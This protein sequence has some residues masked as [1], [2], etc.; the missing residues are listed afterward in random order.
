[1]VSVAKGLFFLGLLAVS[2]VLPT[3]LQADFEAEEGRSRDV[4]R[5]RSV[6]TLATNMA[7][8]FAGV[9][10]EHVDLDVLCQA[11][12]PLADEQVKPLSYEGY[13]YYLRQY[14][15]RPDICLQVEKIPA[16]R[17]PVERH[18]PSGGWK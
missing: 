17:K 13:H 7:E 11:G 12:E 2:F 1:M 5:L 16:P 3:D 10:L 14:E 9:Y 4:K 18:F 6:L 8:A 15:S